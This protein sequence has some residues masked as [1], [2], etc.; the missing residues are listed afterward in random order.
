MKTFYEWISENIIDTGDLTHQVGVQS[1]RGEG[2]FPVGFQPI[3]EKRPFGTVIGDYVRKILLKFSPNK[4]NEHLVKSIVDN[5]YRLY[6]HPQSINDLLP[7]GVDISVY[8]QKASKMQD[9]ILAFKEVSRLKKNNF[10]NYESILQKAYDINNSLYGLNGNIF[11]L[12]RAIILKISRLYY[13]EFNLSNKPFAVVIGDSVRKFLSNFKPSKQ[14]EHLVKGISD[15]LSKLYKYNHSMEDLLPQGE[16]NSVVKADLNIREITSVFQNIVAKLDR[17]SRRKEYLSLYTVLVVARNFSYPNEE[18]GELMWLIQDIIDQIIV[19]Y[20]SEMLLINRDSIETALEN[21][22]YDFELDKSLIDKVKVGLA[23][24]EFKNSSDLYFINFD[25]ILQDIEVLNM[26]NV[27][28]Q[29]VEDTLK[30][31]HFLVKRVGE[32]SDLDRTIKTI[33]DKLSYKEG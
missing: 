17:N 2:E 16:I 21:I 4:K 15:N 31:F 10:Q 8:Q 3:K 30:D 27:S 19:L 33:L 18:V 25:N 14:N 23:N 9:L 32:G 6:R 20:H 24:F 22:I 13:Q 28:L 7:R 1:G 26:G 5:L 11:D 29:G 12:I